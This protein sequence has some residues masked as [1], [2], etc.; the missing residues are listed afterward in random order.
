MIE[1]PNIFK[2]GL[3]EFKTEKEAL[4][5]IN[6]YYLELSGGISRPITE[7][8]KVESNISFKEFNNYVNSLDKKIKY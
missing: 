8:Y 6:N 3:Y 1:H 7:F 2:I 4:N 5:N